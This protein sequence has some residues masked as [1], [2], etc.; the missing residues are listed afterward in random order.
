MSGPDRQFDPVANSALGAVRATNRIAREAENN[1]PA[2]TLPQRS[3]AQRSLV[4]GINTV[5]TISPFN[6]LAGEGPVDSP[7]GGGGGGG[8]GGAPDVAGILPDGA[9]T[10]ESLLPQSLLNVLQD[11]PMPDPP[12]GGGNG[13]GGGGNVGGGGGSGGSSGRSAPSTR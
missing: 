10:P 6:V 2:P 12:T 8:G 7:I 5:S 11:S 9:P 1:T 4:D 3:Q 13:G